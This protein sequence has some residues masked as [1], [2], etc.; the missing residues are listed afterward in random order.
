MIKAEMREVEEYREELGLG[1]NNVILKENLINS[2]DEEMVSSWDVVNINHVSGPIKLYANNKSPELNLT[3]SWNHYINPINSLVGEWLQLVYEF[4]V[5]MV[6]PNDNSIKRM[7]YNIVFDNSNVNSIPESEKVILGNM[8]EKYH[9]VSSA[10]FKLASIFICNE[11]S[12]IKKNEKI[13]LVNP[14][15]VDEFEASH[16]YFNKEL[17]SSQVRF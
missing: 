6:N 3:L 10:A 16:F 5:L 8:G 7:K 14:T 15:V 4:N 17:S 2:F 13:E 9:E 1:V 12:N 11:L